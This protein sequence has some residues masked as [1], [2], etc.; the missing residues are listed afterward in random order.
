MRTSEHPLEIQSIFQPS[1]LPTLREL[2]KMQEESA[3][4]QKRINKL[5]NTTQMPDEVKE[6]LKD[7]GLSTQFIKSQLFQDQMERLAETG[8]FT[9]NLLQGKIGPKPRVDVEVQTDITHIRTQESISVQVPIVSLRPKRCSG[10][11]QTQSQ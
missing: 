2:Q 3:R 4:K 5:A 10:G 7:L 1:K 6:K 8:N 11:Y 9:Q